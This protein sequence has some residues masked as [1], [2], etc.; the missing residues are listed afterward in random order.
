[1]SVT[2]DHSLLLR[3]IAQ[4]LSDLEQSGCVLHV[5]VANETV[6]EKSENGGEVKVRWLCWSVEI[7]GVELVSPKFEVLSPLVSLYRLKKEL[8]SVFRNVE[9]I[10]DDDIEV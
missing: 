9:V 1:M 10:V 2:I 4:T 6:W 8:P 3:R 7:D 5:S